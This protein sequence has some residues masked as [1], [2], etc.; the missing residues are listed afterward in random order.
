MKKSIPNVEDFKSRADY[1]QHR[2]TYWK[3]AA[4]KMRNND[5]MFLTSRNLYNIGCQFHKRLKVETK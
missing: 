1:L 5:K 4:L 3:T 2:V